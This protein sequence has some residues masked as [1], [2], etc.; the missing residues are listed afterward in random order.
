MINHQICEDSF[1]LEIMTTTVPI[2]RLDL[3]QFE[4]VQMSPFSKGWWDEV[5]AVPGWY[6]IET[7]A[8]VL[9]LAALPFPRAEGRHYRIAERLRGVEFLIKNGAAI[10]PPQEGT[11]FIVYSGEHG[12]L[13]ARAREHTHG[14]KGTGCLC[15]S[16]Y[17]A[18][19]GFRWRFYYRTC[20]SHVPGSCGNKMLRTFLEQK[21][22]ADNG[23]PILC[24]E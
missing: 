13:K 11:P 14:N 22:R 6:A 21:W 16:Q 24:A 18:I 4:S 20:E 1:T 7:D 17:E 2:P 23:W 15:L 9:V 5:P 8:P 10:T 12:N 19:C 3:A